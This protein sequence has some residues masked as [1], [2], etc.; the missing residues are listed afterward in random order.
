MTTETLHA[1]APARI[2]GLTNPIDLVAGTF[3]TCVRQGDGRGRVL[4]HHFAADVLA[5]GAGAVE[6]LGAKTTEAKQALDDRH[7]RARVGGAGDDLALILGIG[8]EEFAGLPAE[9][10]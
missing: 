9:P 5:P 4:D 7:Q 2:N 8:R 10:S 1:S 3:H 6:A